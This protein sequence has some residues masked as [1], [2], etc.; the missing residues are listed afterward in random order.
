MTNIINLIKKNEEII[1]YIIVGAFTTFISLISY[2]L[3][4]IV[5]D[6]NDALQLQITNILSWIL[7]VLF[8]FIAN[9]KI[10]FK[11]QTK[12]VFSE[13][14]KFFESR[15]FTLL[16]D[17][18]SMFIMVTILGINDMISKILVQFIVLILNYILSKFIVF[19]NKMEEKK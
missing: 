11:T 10:V 6:P 12:N 1:N 14:F 16:V 2:Y 17:I 19:K 7:S 3:L 8:A 18:I 13:A 5:L 9:K 15:I 4:T